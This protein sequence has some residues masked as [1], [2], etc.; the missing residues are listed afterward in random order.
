MTGVP[1][2]RTLGVMATWSAAVSVGMVSGV[3]V[4][5]GLDRK[6]RR[7]RR[8]PK[9]CGWMMDGDEQP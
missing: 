1:K 6:V 5:M 7:L 2:Y 8:S 4:F 9:D 3:G